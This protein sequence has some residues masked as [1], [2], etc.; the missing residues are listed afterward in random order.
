MITS[1]PKHESFISPRIDGLTV[2]EANSAS[3]DDVT[4]VVRGHKARRGS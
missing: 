4:C 3:I 1:L 2:L